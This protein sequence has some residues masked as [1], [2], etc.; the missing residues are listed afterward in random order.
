MVS[1]MYLAKPYA[2]SS[3]RVA[4]RHGR[5][6]TARTSPPAPSPPLPPALRWRAAE[7]RAKYRMSGLGFSIQS[8]GFRFYRVATSQDSV[9]LKRGG[10]KLREM[11]WQA[12]ST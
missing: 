12:V 11:A 7:V 10:V 2:S 5:C 8:L 1:I 6:A 3:R 9:L 4:W